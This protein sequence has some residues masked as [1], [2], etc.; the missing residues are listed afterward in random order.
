MTEKKTLPARKIFKHKELASKIA[1]LTEDLEELRSEKALLLKHLDYAEDAEAETF[2]KD[3]SA[4]EASLQKLEAQEQKYSVE[5]ET[6][7]QEYALSLI[8]IWVTTTR[9]R[10]RKGAFAMFRL[11]T[12]KK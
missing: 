1:E 4:L 3:I 6:V 7:L 12:K 10:W 9:S 5:L 11:D 2:R 8:H